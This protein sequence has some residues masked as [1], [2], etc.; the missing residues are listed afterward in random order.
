MR[1]TPA[2][3]TR[4][5]DKHTKKDRNFFSVWLRLLRDCR[6]YTSGILLALFFVLASTALTIFAP[7]KLAELT[8]LVATSLETGVEMP[9][10]LRLA[11]I[12]ALL[13]V[14]AA[15][16]SGISRFV[17]SGL[18]QHVSHH[19]RLH[20]FQKINRMDARDCDST[21]TGDVL[22]RTVNDVDAVG[23]A[24]HETLAD[25]IPAVAMLTGSLVMMA[26][27][28]MTLTVVAVVATSLGFGAMLLIMSHAQKYFARGQKHLGEMS[29]HVEEIYTAHETVR[30][31]GGEA[32]VRETFRT[33]NR[34]LTASTYHARF[35]TGLLSPLLTFI[36]NFGYLAVCVVGALLVMGNHISFGVIVAFMFFV[37]HFSHPFAEIAAVMQA[38]QSAAAAGDR[39]YE[40]LESEEENEHADTRGLAAP[41][42][43]HVTFSHVTFRYPENKRAV[44]KDLTLDVPPGTRVA[45]LGREGS[46]KTTLAH[47]LAGFYAPD[48][49]EICIDGV[50]VS[51]LSRT[52]LHECF[53]Y[54]VQAPWIF[55]GT[56]R[57]NLA[58][59][60]EG[61]SDEEIGEVCDRVGLGGFIR[62]L[63]NG[64]DTLL[65][66]GITL[67]EGR[68]QQI[69]ITLSEGRRQQ[70][71]IARALLQR[72]P[73]F[74]FDEAMTA[75]DPTVEA[76][77]IHA[78]EEYTKGHTTFLI[79]HR[80]LSV[81]HADLILV[82]EEGH[83]SEKGTHEELMR[84]NG[85][86][87]EL[88]R[89]AFH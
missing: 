39:V 71:G 48:Q 17:M 87:A 41:V 62:S 68:R 23:H 3:G 15:V 18:T 49:G 53:S 10:F 45:V 77:V 28:D 7:L 12:A 82:M 35:L 9:A 66:H 33:L 13:Y 72:R 27:T 63:P 47:L 6:P 34:K 79:S 83:I 2:N 8:D 57:E 69:G 21:A 89:R 46:G 86:Y 78:L 84:A 43:G 31:C 60:T 24:L 70:I 37:H 50:P 11:G 74:I 67:S 61:L 80:P 19:I 73:M 58:Y 14:L 22:S 65:G 76:D 75:L 51:E 54:V 30:S 81:R 42:R 36:A 44:V 1:K 4:Y 40:F 32:T 59:C 29:A 85:Y 26:L 52:R 25:L 20:V 88:C 38:L 5:A 56:V 16:T 55:E 64:Y